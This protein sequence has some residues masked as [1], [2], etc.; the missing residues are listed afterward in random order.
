MGV[1]AEEPKAIGG[2]YLDVELAM[3]LPMPSP[4]PLPI[5]ELLTVRMSCE[6]CGFRG[7]GRATPSVM[8]L[9]F[10]DVEYLDGRECLGNNLGQGRDFLAFGAAQTRCKLST[11][12]S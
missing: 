5:D 3:P 2:T 11:S 9:I 12:G 4:I 7:R 6:C 8:L 1:G 10:D